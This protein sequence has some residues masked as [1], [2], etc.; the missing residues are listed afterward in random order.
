M[1]SAPRASFEQAIKLLDPLP[2]RYD[3]ARVHFAFGLTLRRAGR[4]AEADA[5]ISTARDAYLALGADTYVA[6]CDRELAASG[7]NAVR[8]HRDFDELTP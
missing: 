6:R 1:I 7:V 5:V 2:L 3:R 4:R 8:T